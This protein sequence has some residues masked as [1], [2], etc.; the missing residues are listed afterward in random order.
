M[1]HKKQVVGEM[2]TVLGKIIS[3]VGRR[4]KMKGRAV[5]LSS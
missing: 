4:G 3:T 2:V 5:I 1:F